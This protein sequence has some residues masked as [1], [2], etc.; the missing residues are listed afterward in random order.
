MLHDLYKAVFLVKDNLQLQLLLFLYIYQAIQAQYTFFLDLGPV[1]IKDIK[2]WFNS[3]KELRAWEVQTCYLLSVYT[4][5]LFLAME[6]DILRHHRNITTFLRDHQLGQ[7][8][9]FLASQDSL[10]SVYNTDY[11]ILGAWHP[12]CS[13]LAHLY[14]LQARVLHRSL[15]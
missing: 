7:D 8:P 5:D 14:L 13:I 4:G 11:S 12:N 15:W 10:L 1:V 3:I 9:G 6:C 2:C